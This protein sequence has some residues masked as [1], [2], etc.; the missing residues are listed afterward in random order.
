MVVRDLDMHLGVLMISDAGEVD[1]EL[2]CSARTVII[3][4]RAAEYDQ[5]AADLER[6]VNQAAE[7]RFL[8]ERLDAIELKDAAQDCRDRLEGLNAE[9]AQMWRDATSMS[10]DAACDMLDQMG[11]EASLALK[12]EHYHYA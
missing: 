7:V 9:F 1:P 3:A 10:H 8:A 12:S 11:L 5:F 2:Q 6:V 4:L